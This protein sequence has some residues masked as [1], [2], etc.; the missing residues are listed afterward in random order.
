[1]LTTDGKWCDIPRDGLLDA[2]AFHHVVATYDGH[3]MRLFFDGA[4]VGGLPPDYV[5]A[6]IRELTATSSLFGVGAGPAEAEA[7]Q[8]AANAAGVV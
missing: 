8:A 2:E 5:P 4:P 7:K 1:M 3:M 6:R